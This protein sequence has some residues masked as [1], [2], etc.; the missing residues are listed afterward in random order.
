MVST[1]VFAISGFCILVVLI[2]I[3]RTLSKGS[4][5]W[6][7]RG[8]VPMVDKAGTGKVCELIDYEV[9]D[10]TKKVRLRLNY[11]GGKGIIQTGYWYD[12]VLDFYP[13]IEQVRWE[14][15]MGTIICY[16]DVE[17]GQKDYRGDEIR[18]IT[19]KFRL[20]SRY[21]E[22]MKKAAVDMLSFYEKQKVNTE[23]E[24]EV[25]KHSKALNAIKKLVN[26]GE[27]NIN[28]DSLKGFGSM[29]EE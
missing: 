20:Q 15:Y 7:L 22:V 6:T 28:A 9:N 11:M 2:V 17:T 8:G 29:V 24:K 10:V 3:F 12:P 13:S 27:E 19:D 18:H 16:R 21:I 4:L 26:M 1:L 14:D 5:V 25:F 23:Q